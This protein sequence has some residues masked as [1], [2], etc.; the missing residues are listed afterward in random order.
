MA[1]LHI[2]K[3]IGNTPVKIA[4]GD[5]DIDKSAPFVVTLTSGASAV[6]G[7]HTYEIRQGQKASGPLCNCA[8][9]I[10]G[11]ATFNVSAANLAA[12]QRREENRRQLTEF[13]TALAAVS[14][15]VAIEIAEDDLKNL[16]AA[17]YALC[18]AKKVGEGNSGDGVYN[19]VW[20]SL[21]N[22]LSSTTFSWTPQYQMFGTNTFQ[23][24]VKVV[25]QTNFQ[26]IGL[27]EECVLDSSGYL[28]PAASG[29]AEI[30]VTMINEYGNIHPGLSQ[31]STLNG[32][33]V[34][35]PLYVAESV[36][37]KGTAVLT[38]IESVLV[39]FEQNIATSTMFSTS[40][41]NSVEID[42]TFTN[43]AT[44]LYQNQHWSTP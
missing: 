36:I 14:K 28:E 11:L 15:S 34:S 7:G 6:K 12:E 13:Y 1:K 43:S 19:V 41:S 3:K 40:R 32:V 29:G 17:N 10:N 23:D 20:Q 22:Y 8:G 9:V 37:V 25:A 33:S 16:K 42:L 26:T 21:T 2:Y 24:E 30:S 4:D 18:F 5:G 44:R 35:T 39:W 27:G 38:P 31:L